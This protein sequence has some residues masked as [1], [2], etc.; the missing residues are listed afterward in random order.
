MLCGGVLHRDEATVRHSCFG[1]D[2]TRSAG[3]WESHPPPPS[4][5]SLPPRAPSFLSQASAPSHGRASQIRGPRLQCRSVV[6]VTTLGG[7][8]TTH[9]RRQVLGQRRRLGLAPVPEQ[10]LMSW[11][12]KSALILSL[13]RSIWTQRLA[14]EAS[15]S[16]YVAAAPRR[17]QASWSRILK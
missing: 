5:P 13:P 6:A 2:P 4:L 7:S 15:G 12:S 17:H 10:K 1:T 9:I 3:P 11:A 8:G 16:A 14:L